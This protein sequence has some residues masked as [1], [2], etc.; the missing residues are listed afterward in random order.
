M[1]PCLLGLCQETPEARGSATVSPVT[2]GLAPTEYWPMHNTHHSR[3][4]SASAELQ[5]VNVV[6]LNSIVRPVSGSRKQNIGDGKAVPLVTARVL[7]LAIADASGGSA[8]KGC[9]HYYMDTLT[10]FDRQVRG[11][12]FRFMIPLDER[13]LVTGRGHFFRKEVGEHLKKL[14]RLSVAAKHAQVKQFTRDMRVAAEEYLVERLFAPLAPY[15]QYTSSSEVGKFYDQLAHYK[16]FEPLT[17][18]PGFREFCLKRP[19]ERHEVRLVEFAALTAG[20]CS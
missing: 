10:W 14:L 15:E 20:L 8:V 13:G 1:S 17:Q 2:L 5:G 7:A 16:C 6:A 11:Q 9:L 18:D 4:N 19:I 3:T 12:P